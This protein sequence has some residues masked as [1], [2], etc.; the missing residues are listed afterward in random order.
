[1]SYRY[2]RIGKHFV[3]VDQPVLAAIRTLLLGYEQNRLQSIGVSRHASRKA[4][5]FV[6][7]GKLGLLNSEQQLALPVRGQ[8]ALLVHRGFKVFDFER[9]EV[10]KVFDPGVSSEVAGKE[11]AASRRASGVAA[12][13]AFIAEDAEGAWYK[14]EY[15]CGVHA[16]DAEFRDGIDILDC[17]A[18]VEKCLLDLVASGQLTNVDA[19]THFDRQADLSFRDRWLQAGC[20]QEDVD[21]ISAY[22]ESLRDWLFAQHG[23]DQLQLVLSHGDFSLVNA[24]S[25]NNGLRF[26]DWEGVAPRGLYNDVFNF[27]FVERYYER[28]S[29]NFLDEMSEF[30]DRYCA[31]IQAAVP[32]LS[33]A[34]RQDL[35]VARRQY[36]LERLR[37]LLDRAESQNLGSVV[38]KS[39]EM[40][41]DFDQQVG[42]AAVEVP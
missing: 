31:A 40:F 26:I 38:L 4:V 15:V 21:E 25:T 8:I 35:A 19:R 2:H 36:Y 37:L 34:S 39:I 1:M 30:I 12:A 33:D 32:A 5:Q 14:E 17:Y 7:R 27:L 11:I 41:R 28:A 20:N 13:P 6:A 24:I 3:C 10:T 29:A 22:V 18:D 16:T 42:D 9:R 23:P